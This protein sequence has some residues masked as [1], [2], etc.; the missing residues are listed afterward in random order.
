MTAAGLADLAPAEPFCPHYGP[1]GGCQLQHVTDE[2]ARQWKTRRLADALAGRGVPL[3]SEGIGYV[4]AE[5]EGRRRLTLHARLDRDRPIV[6]YMSAGSHAIVPIAACPV[7]VPPL[8]QAPDLVTALAAA[9]G[10]FRRIDA[11]LTASATG[12][13]CDLAA[14]DPSPAIRGRLAEIAE[15]LDLARLTA[16]GE[17]LALRRQPV[18]VIGRASVPLPPRSFLQATARGEAE[19]ADFALGALAGSKRVVDLFCGVGAFALRLAET[20]PVSAFDVD[21]PSIAALKSA[22]AHAQGLKPVQAAARDLF[23]HPLTSRELQAF[24]AALFDPPR[25]GAEAQARELASARLRR[26]LAIS[27]DARTFA[28][29][30]RIL[31]DAGW[32]MASV[33]I[34]DQFRWTTHLEIAALF[35]RTGDQSTSTPLDRR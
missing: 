31:H 27:C 8:R 17:P 5:G 29:D 11:Q 6:G 32:T 22:A 4:L 10:R 15:S 21:A 20:T 33:A 14:I 2:A 9:A 1:C 12:I 18:V 30:T 34:V 23:R 25:Q 28:R 19:L 13:D 24:D 26:I 7:A 35:R 16:A 3:P